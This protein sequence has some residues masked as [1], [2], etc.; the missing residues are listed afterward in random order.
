MGSTRVRSFQLWLILI[1]MRTAANPENR[2]IRFKAETEKAGETNGQVK[3]DPQSNGWFSWARRDV[4]KPVLALVLWSPPLR[5]RTPMEAD[6]MDIALSLSRA[7]GSSM[8]INQISRMKAFRSNARRHTLDWRFER[9][10]SHQLLVV[11]LDNCKF[12]GRIAS[13]SSPVSC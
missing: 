10:S 12:H 3:S 8:R 6:S 13:I 9:E 4:F 5:R 11:M 7:N 1:L 2:T